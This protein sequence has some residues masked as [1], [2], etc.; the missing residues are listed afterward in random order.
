MSDEREQRLAAINAQLQT[1]NLRPL[2]KL[3]NAQR[4]EI[5]ILEITEIFDHS[6]RF[7]TDVKFRVKFP[8][9]TEGAFTLRFNANGIVSDGAAFVVIVNG[10]FAIVKQW[11]PALCRWTYEV[12]RGFGEKVDQARVKG[13]LGTVGIGDLPLGTITREL[14]EEVMR[15]ATVTSITHLGN[16]AENSGTNRVT[17]GNYLVILS[18]PPDVLEG[19]LSGSEEL[20]VALWDTERVRAEIGQRLN[21]NHTLAALFLAFEHIRKLPSLTA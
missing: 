3:G 1:R 13:A 17:P 4:G 18:V 20:K 2:E 16:T 9:T 14:G 21:D 5:E 15:E 12:P 10:K 19:R 6:A 8:N 7:F 11:R